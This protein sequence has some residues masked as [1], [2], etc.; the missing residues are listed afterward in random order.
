MF[1]IDHL[2]DASLSIH[3]LQFIVSLI[4]VSMPM[5]RETAML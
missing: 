3:V 2:N 4:H 1:S 5:M